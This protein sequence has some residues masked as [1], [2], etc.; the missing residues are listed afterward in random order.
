MRNFC[1]L[2]GGGGVASPFFV[3]FFLLATNCICF[4]MSANATY[5]TRHT[6]QHGL[7]RD[8]SFLALPADKPGSCICV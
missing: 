6:A 5:L 7:G 8:N 2:Y 3:Y 1:Q 4:L